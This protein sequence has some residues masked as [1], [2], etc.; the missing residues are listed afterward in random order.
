M[1]Q[2][3]SLD[4]PAAAHEAPPALRPPAQVMRLARL[5]RSFATRLSFMPSLLRRLGRCGATVERALWD[6]DREGYGRA[7]LTVRLE[8]RTYSL[9]AFSQHL[10]PEA[11]SDRVI[12]EAWDATFALF[13]G[14]PTTAE[15]DALEANAPRQEAG[16]YDAKVLVLSRANKS[17]RM[18]EHTVERLAAGRQPDPEMV[19]GVG[20]LMRT[21]A[22]YGNGKFG[23]ADRARIAQRPEFAGAFQAE[24]L[25]VY[26]IRCFTQELAEHVAQE[27]AEARGGAPA[28]RLDPAIRRYLGVGNSTGLGMAPFLVGHPVL[29]NN[30]IMAREMALARVRTLTRVEPERMAAF[31]R[32]VARARAHVAEWCVDDPE[33]TAGTARLRAELAELSDA[34]A[35]GAPVWQAPRPWDRLYRWAET[36]MGV[37]GQELTVS[38]LLEPHGDLVDGLTECMTAPDGG[39]LDPAMTVGRLRDL[40]ALHYDWAMAIDFDDPRAAA[41]FWY[42]SEEKLEPRL[43]ERARE[44]GADKE[45]PV[46]V[47]R[48]VQALDR[49]LAGAPAG[50]RLGRFLLRHPELRHVAR[51]VQVVAQHPYGEIQDNLID[52]ACRPLDLLR[53]KLAFF[54]AG[55]F[56]PK[57]D[58]WTRIA[59][60]QG[61]PLP[62]ELGTCAAEDWCLPALGTACAAMP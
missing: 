60:Y 57:S 26:L 41:R 30:W 22:V 46:A 58:R 59:M 25:A 62:E 9:V 28:V 43:G 47:A 36:T 52:A 42:V 3:E 13:D 27:R 19:A 7:V 32:L 54:G 33:Q 24:M 37:E 20:Y 48:D 53:C 18:F 21:T 61:A 16:R 51:R 8:G 4:T 6:L 10:A 15:L 38:L 50:E 44:P 40:V 5:G 12:A 39:Q 2:A 23:I 49:A 17:V 56:D 14:L 35:E 55:K 11:R 45:M 31:R 29:L 34:A 1:L